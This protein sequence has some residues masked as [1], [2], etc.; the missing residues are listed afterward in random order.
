LLT[1]VLATQNKDKLRELQRMMRGTKFK[2]APLSDFSRMPKVREDGA[3]FEANAEK[4]ARVYSRKT[5]SL[6]IADDSGLEVRALGG[7]PGVY[8][9]RFAGR[10]CTYADNNRKL[11]RMLRSTAAPKRDAKFVSVISAYDNGKKI[12]TVRGECEGRIGFMEKGENGFGYDPVFVPRGSSKTYA[13]LAAAEK[14]RVS[15]RGK[16]LRKIRR[17]LLRLKP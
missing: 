7:R 2:V 17:L 1:L 4:K 9:A 8:S 12:G 11:L 3:T 5:K 14:N 16:A 15:H 10:G 6:V 13:E